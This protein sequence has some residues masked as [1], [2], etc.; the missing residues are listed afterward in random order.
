MTFLAVGNSIAIGLVLAGV[1]L[2]ESNKVGSF[3]PESFARFQLARIHLSYD[4]V[5]KANMYE[6]RT[7]RCSKEG[8][9]GHST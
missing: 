2:G 3:F 8:C 5:N 7:K 1:D 6:K 4:A 9:M